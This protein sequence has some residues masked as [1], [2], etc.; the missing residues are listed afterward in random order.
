MEIKLEQ[1]LQIIPLCMRSQ[2]EQ[3]PQT[4]NQKLKLQMVLLQRNHQAQWL[5]KWQSKNCGLAGWL[6]QCLFVVSNT[7]WQNSGLKKVEVTHTHT[8]QDSIQTWC[9]LECTW[10]WH[11]LPNNYEMD[12]CKLDGIEFI[13]NKTNRIKSS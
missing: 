7:L 3:S 13:T 1:I 6:Q 2:I 9:L 11:H 12:F 8:L 4:N 10:W 5:L